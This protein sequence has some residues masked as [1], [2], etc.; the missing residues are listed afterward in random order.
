[1]A[2]TT[3]GT[4][5]AAPPKFHLV[6]P[7]F[8]ET[9]WGP[10]P[11]KGNDTVPEVFHLVTKRYP[12]RLYDKAFDER[13]QDEWYNNSR[14]LDFVRRGEQADPELG[15]KIVDSRHPKQPRPKKRLPPKPS[16]QVFQ[17]KQ[18]MDKAELFKQQKQEQRAKRGMH[19]RLPHGGG[20]I[21]VLVACEV[22]EGDVRR[23]GESV[24]RQTARQPRLRHSARDR[25]RAAVGGRRNRD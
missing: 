14:L 23:G 4:P 2:A 12:F 9:G 3:A 7:K 6:V 13:V 17:Q 15:Y 8:N 1:M 20:P 21:K 16:T 10:T 5:V 19:H 25:L 24:V 11:V 18:Q 22:D